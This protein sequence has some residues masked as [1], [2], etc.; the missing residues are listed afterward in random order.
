MTLTAPPATAGS[1]PQG[2]RVEAV[3]QAGAILAAAFDEVRFGH[4]DDAEAVAVLAAL[5][6]LGRKVDGAQY[7]L[8]ALSCLS[9]SWTHDL[10]TSWTRCLTASETL[11]PMIVRECRILFHP[12]LV[13][14][15]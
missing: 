11:A 9:A 6:G 14:R 15:S 8:T 4:L 2:S 7:Q 1:M 3:A 10:M 5:E 12:R 13:P